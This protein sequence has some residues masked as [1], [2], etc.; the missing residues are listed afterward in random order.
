MVT[1]SDPLYSQQW[2]LRLLGDINTVWNEYS[3]AGIS[4]G[5]Y[6][7][8]LQYNHPDLDG[9]Y[10]A[11][12]H[13]RFGG[14]TYNP[15]PISLV[16]DGH[17]TSVA[18]L[19]AAEAGN[20]IGGVGVAW[21]ATLTGVNLLSDARFYDDSGLDIRA[22]RYFATFDVVNNSW[23]YDPYFYAFLDR[24]NPLE[25]GAAVESAFAYA[26]LNGRDGLGTVI[27]MPMAKA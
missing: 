25:Y 23:G 20:G 19:I 18:G 6:D 16:R 13:F 10:N 8:G 12:L 24:G 2:H 3:G 4:V 22:F 17:G 11:S 14:V 1:F 7:D 15:M 21:G 26:A 27:S 5:V 9:N